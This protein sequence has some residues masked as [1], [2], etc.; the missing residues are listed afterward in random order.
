MNLTKAENI[1]WHHHAVTRADREKL[2]RRR[3]RVVWLTGLSGCGKS[4]IAGALESML[5]QQ[6]WPTMLLDGDNVRH[7]LC[8]PPDRLTAGYG[9]AFAQRFG[10]GFS[11]MD[12]TEN[13]RRIA[14][15]CSLMTSAGLV[16]IAAFVSPMLDQRAAV[17][18]IVQSADDAGPDD[19][20]E[21]FVDTPLEVCKSRD[22]KGLYKKAMAGEIADFTGI[23][24]PYQPPASPEV[25]LKH[26]AGRTPADDAATILAYLTSAER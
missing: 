2:A 3:G 25:H 23:S 20:V 18:Q 22:P 13:L 1:V 19:F 24:S 9:D 5:I 6:R 26:E 17:R 8:A 14:S 10:L 7:G 11:D 4:T 16:T 12:R 15:V 21:V